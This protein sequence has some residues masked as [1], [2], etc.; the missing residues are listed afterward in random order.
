MFTCACGKAPQ[1]DRG[2]QIP[3][4]AGGPNLH[5]NPLAF[6][7]RSNRRNLQ[8]TQRW[9]RLIEG[10]SRLIW[11]RNHGSKLCVVGRGLPPHTSASKLRRLSFAARVGAWLSVAPVDKNFSDSRVPRSS[12]A[13]FLR[14]PSSGQNFA[15]QA[16]VCSRSLRPPLAPLHAFI[17]GRASRA[18]TPRKEPNKLSAFCLLCARRP[19][20]P[21]RHPLANRRRAQR[22]RPRARN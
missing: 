1:L 11:M 3:V 6:A 22:G 19:G 13:S 15:E 20:R 14:P 16:C 4:A 21:N 12:R 5:Q 8:P 10:Q 2:T 17:Q 18:F 9:A 7:A